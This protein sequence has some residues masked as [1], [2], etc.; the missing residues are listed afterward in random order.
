M[1]IQFERNHKELTFNKEQIHSI[2]NGSDNQIVKRYQIRANI[3]NVYHNKDYNLKRDEI[4][5]DE[6]NYFETNNLSI[7]FSELD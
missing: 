5:F 4:T 7:P 3:V 1:T 6:N 2:S